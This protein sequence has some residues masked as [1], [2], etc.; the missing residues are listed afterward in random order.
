[1]SEQK[2]VPAEVVPG[3]VWVDNDI[4]SRGSGEF[5][6]LSVWT[7][8]EGVGRLRAGRE[9]AQVRRYDTDRLTVIASD[10][11]LAG[12]DSK[13]GYTYVGMQR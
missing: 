7:A 8:G 3:Q 4:R 9:Y 13:R 10:R 1:M 5:V 11:L 12:R 2:K 6:V